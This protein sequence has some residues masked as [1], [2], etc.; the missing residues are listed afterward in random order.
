MIAI[1]GI[2]E[3][4][5]L[6]DLRTHEGWQQTALRVLKLV[7]LLIPCLVRDFFRKP[8]V[9]VE[10]GNTLVTAF[11]AQ[12][13]QLCVVVLPI[14][15]AYL[16][17]EHW[18]AFDFSDLASPML[19]GCKLVAE[20]TGCLTWAHWKLDKELRTRLLSSPVPELNLH[21]ISIIDL[22]GCDDQGTDLL[23]KFE[24][25][26]GKTLRL[27]EIHAVAHR[28]IERHAAQIVV[29]AELD[30]G[31]DIFEKE[32]TFDETARLLE[33][34]SPKFTVIRFSSTHTSRPKVPVETM[35]RFINKCPNA[36][37]VVNP[38]PFYDEQARSRFEQ[39]LPGRSITSITFK[40]L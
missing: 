7:M 23:N 26:E 32:R 3:T 24:S 36:C 39:Q 15:Q 2:P 9:R 5:T 34:Q 31:C 19:K 28:L 33:V 35:V 16:G 1:N 8:E 10:N 20:K 18:G 25:L 27:P 22:T 21:S 29:L 40:F 14:V 30:I 4:K 11:H 17:Q 12:H 37:V 6:F 38:L 13:Y